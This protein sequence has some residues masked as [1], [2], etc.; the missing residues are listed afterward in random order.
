MTNGGNLRLLKLTLGNLNLPISRKVET[1]AAMTMD[2]QREPGSSL[3][4]SEHRTGCWASVET[5]ACDVVS[6]G[7]GRR[8]SES[9]D[10]FHAVVLWT[11]EKAS[12]A[13]SALPYRRLH[14][15]PAGQIRSVL[16]VCSTTV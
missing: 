5:A 6:A 7:K 16:V 9:R 8:L 12:G 3:A 1:I 15:I 13:Q 11:A 2:R 14:M 10:T 4:A